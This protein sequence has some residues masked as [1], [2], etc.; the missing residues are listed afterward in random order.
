[1]RWSVVFHFLMYPQTQGSA[2]NSKS[3]PSRNCFPIL[4]D[5]TRAAHPRS[6]NTISA[7]LSAPS[8]LHWRSVKIISSRREKRTTSYG[9]EFRFL[10]ICCVLAS[11]HACERDC[12]KVW[13]PRRGGS[14][15]GLSHTSEWTRSVLS[16][17]R[18]LGF[19]KEGSIKR[20]WSSNYRML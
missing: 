8:R 11:T 15:L 4:V 17:A 16:T 9:S 20:N 12:E 1:M 2:R 13:S 3:K 18:S 19:C 7:E 14:T 6:I 5:S 10:Q